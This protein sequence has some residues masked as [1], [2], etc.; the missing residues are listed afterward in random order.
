[1]PEQL[2][3]QPL[4]IDYK[5]GASGTIAAAEVARAAPDGYTLALLDNAPLTIV[6]AFRNTGY[7]PLAASPTSAWSPSCRRCWSL[8]PRRV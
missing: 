6:P 1:M 4:V 2:L 5:S 8:R 7:D 3:G